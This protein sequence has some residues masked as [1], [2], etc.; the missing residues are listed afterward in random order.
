MVSTSQ[1]ATND[2]G[3]VIPIDRHPNDSI[4][5]MT[6]TNPSDL[7]DLPVVSSAIPTLPD[8]GPANTNNSN[9]W[10]GN[11]NTGSL[12]DRDQANGVPSG[13]NDNDNDNN[14][15]DPT[16]DK[17]GSDPLDLTSDD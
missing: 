6:N 11:D 16:P 4:P 1:V 3:T 5:M 14:D 9:N 15:I 8:P 17:R 7:V 2:A 12:A 13:N 10:S